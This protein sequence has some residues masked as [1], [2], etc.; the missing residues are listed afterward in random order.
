MLHY[1]IFTQ[2]FPNIGHTACCSLH[3]Y[4]HPCT[5]TLSTYSEHTTL[6]TCSL[7]LLLAHSFMLL[8]PTHLNI[9][10]F[11]LYS[12]DIFVALY[13]FTLVWF[14]FT[15]CIY[16]FKKLHLPLLKDFTYTWSHSHTFENICK[17]Y[18]IHLPHVFTHHLH[19][20]FTACMHTSA[21]IL[22]LY[23]T[24]AQHMLQ[25]SC[26]LQELFCFVMFDSNQWNSRWK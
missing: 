16:T 7:L 12:F 18:I 15:C 3:L 22:H 10:L 23:N 14:N 9:F 4:L 21:Y 2:H 17:H 13:S 11:I 8:F 20:A 6:H 19:F 1:T 26:S 5:C 25:Y 24:Q